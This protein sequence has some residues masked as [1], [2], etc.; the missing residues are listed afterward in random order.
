M[1]LLQDM[2]DAIAEGASIEKFREIIANGFDIN[3]ADEILVPVTLRSPGS[4]YTPLVSAILSSDQETLRILLL[5]GADPCGPSWYSTGRWLLPIHFA[6]RVG[7]ACTELLVANGAHISGVGSLGHTALHTTTQFGWNNTDIDRVMVLLELGI[8]TAIQDQLGK[9][10][11]HYNRCSHDVLLR[12]AEA[13]TIDTLD[14]QDYNG[15]TILNCVARNTTDPH[16]VDIVNILMEKGASV[17]I[18]N[19]VGETALDVA[20]GHSPECAARI[21]FVTRERQERAVAIGLSRLERAGAWSLLG[22]LPIEL[23]RELILEAGTGHNNSVSSVLNL[24]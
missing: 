13:A 14:L 16:A 5:L 7:R 2:H 10:A 23:L 20:R 4:K 24:R 22:H 8:D 3:Q 21:L 17:F 1:S 12:I 11:L 9:T 6:S 19:N 18:S 15:D